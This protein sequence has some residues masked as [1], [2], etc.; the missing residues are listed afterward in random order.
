MLEEGRG[1]PADAA[2]A[3]QLYRQA[4]AQNFAPAQNNLGIL[5]AEGR[6]VAQNL[7]EAY[8]WLAIAVSNGAKPTGRD[9][10]AQQLTPSQAAEAKTVL[11]TLQ[12]QLAGGGTPTAAVAAATPAAPPQPASAAA[13]SQQA[14]VNAR[15]AVLQAETEKLQTE[16]TRLSQAAHD[17]EQQKATLQQQLTAAAKAAESSRASAADRDKLANELAAAQK[18]VA[19]ARATNERL[20]QENARLR[21]VADHPAPAE[22]NAAALRAQLD[23]A[24]HDKQLAEQ[25]AADL[26]AE[27]KAS[28]TT[29][30]TRAI[31]RPR[32]PTRGL[33]I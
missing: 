3:A 31:R 29:R 7:P 15:I 25:K 8:A 33:S 13:A 23:Q 9:I 28:S 10:V 27:L 5:L 21:V 14:A 16:N 24:T 22:S 11:A 6:G 2:A 32:R 4:A 12:A 19:E 18:A 30:R 17:L 20:T 1:A 26:A